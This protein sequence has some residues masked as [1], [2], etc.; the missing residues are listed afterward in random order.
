MVGVAASQAGLPLDRNP[1]KSGQGR[2]L[3][4]CGYIEG[5]RRVLALSAPES[6][7]K[8]M[9]EDS[10]AIETSRLRKLPKPDPR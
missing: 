3:W 8:A 5:L 1:A 10:R 9:N 6:A 4:L 2:E 7:L